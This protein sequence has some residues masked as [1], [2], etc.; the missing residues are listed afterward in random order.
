MP[1]RQVNREGTCVAPIDR[2]YL[3]LVV[4]EESSPWCM[5]SP[6][7]P[8][9]LS[10]TR[11]TR[12]ASRCE[13]SA[14]AAFSKRKEAHLEAR[15]VGLHDGVAPHRSRDVPRHGRLTALVDVVVVCGHPRG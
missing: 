1:R 11:L 12:P 15:H 5:A 6:W 3:F 13:L 7:R 14:P 4:A 9:T 10:A 8:V 2:M